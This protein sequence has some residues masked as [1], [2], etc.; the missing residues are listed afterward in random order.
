MKNNDNG[1]AKATTASANDWHVSGRAPERVAIVACGPTSLDWHAA[2]FLYDPAVDYDEIWVVN[3]G[4]RTLRCDV[5]FV[6]DDLV[7]EARRSRRYQAD[8]DALQVPI[9]TSTVDD[10]V[11]GLF[12]NANLTAYPINYVLA[13]CA[14][15]I[16]KARKCEPTE[17]QLGATMSGLAN[18]I[19]NSI[20]Y[21]LAYAGFIGVKTVLLFGADYTFPG[22]PAREDDQANCEYWVGLMRGLGVD[23]SVP[24]TTT[25]L[26]TR[27]RKPMYGFGARPPQL[28]IPREHILQRLRE[29]T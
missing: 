22:S 20:P 27:Y 28:M 26:A 21:L 5:A 29:R 9:I 2:N 13:W 3:K 1:G 14:L 11:R 7:G 16:W 4:I 18:Y 6:M 15:K 10:S 23:V 25:L 17:A 24:D 19:H 8:I 12:P